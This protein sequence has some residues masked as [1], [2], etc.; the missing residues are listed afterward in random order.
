LTTLAPWYAVLCAGT[1]QGKED[2]IQVLAGLAPSNQTV[3]S[4]KRVIYEQAK[5]C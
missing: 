1:I 3:G 4:N 2:V 5:H